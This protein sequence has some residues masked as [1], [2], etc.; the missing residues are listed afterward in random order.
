MIR[1]DDIEYASLSDVGVR[2]SHNQDSYA[3]LPATDL[4]Q[5][6]GRGHVLPQDVKE[7]ALDVLRH[8]VILTYEAEA[9]EKTSEA[10]IRSI[11][12]AIPVP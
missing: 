10:I 9:E 6:H 8:R 12:N 4:E 5:W 2:R 11:L 3:T 7:L 1:F